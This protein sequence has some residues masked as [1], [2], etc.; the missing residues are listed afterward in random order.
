MANKTPQISPSTIFDVSNSVS[1]VKYFKYENFS[2]TPEIICINKNKTFRPIPTDK[3]YLE[4]LNIQ[5]VKKHMP[6]INTQS[7][8]TPKLTNTNLDISSSPLNIT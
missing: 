2:P 4:S 1:G 3:A 5:L 6:K 8:N 7:P